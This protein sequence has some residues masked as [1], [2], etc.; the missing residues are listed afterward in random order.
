MTQ[1]ETL[2]GGLG[3][4]GRDPVRHALFLEQAAPARDQ[5]PWQ[6]LMEQAL[7]GLHCRVMPS[8]SDEAPGLLASVAPP[9]GTHH[10]PALCP[11]QHALSQAVSAPRAT[12]QRAAAKAAPQA[13]E[14]GQRRP[15]R[16][17]HAHDTSAQRAPGR[18]PQIAA[19]LE[20][21][22]LDVEAA[23]PEHRRLTGP[24]EPVTQSLRAIGHGDHL[25]DLERGVR[26]NGQRMAG[27]LPQPSDTMRTMAPQEGRSATGLD[28]IEKAARGAHNAGD[29]RVRRGVCAP[30]GQPT[31]RAAAGGLRPACASPS[32]LFSRTRSHHADG[33]RGR[34]ASCP[35]QSPPRT[36]V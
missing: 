11:V 25:V 8:T 13:E 32:R 29:Q 14:T 9:L 12:P 36:A 15:E 23:G 22:G 7:A 5:A 26:R 33:A 31:G 35:R 21:G 1:E 34:A 4:V 24:R 18:P 27:A 16:L 2:T 6:A 3:L 20:Q 19:R 10:A 30:A 17:D 28:R